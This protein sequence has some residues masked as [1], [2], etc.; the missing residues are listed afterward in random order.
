MASSPWPACTSVRARASA[1]PV[2]P[3]AGCAL[4][5]PLLTLNA[6]PP[7]CHD[8]DS[9]SRHCRRRHPARCH[10][11]G[12]GAHQHAGYNAT[13]RFLP[14]NLCPE[15]LLPL[16]LLLTAMTLLLP[17][18]YAPPRPSRRHMR[19]VSPSSRPP[20]PRSC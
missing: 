18:G 2:R 12:A 14:T 1:P 7:L 6:G 17:Q 3:V 13:P 10:H 16:L 5:P 20:R 9:A 19:G 15:L 8:T 11:Q 4:V